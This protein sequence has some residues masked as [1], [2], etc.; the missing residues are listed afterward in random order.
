[1]PDAPSVLTSGSKS[2]ILVLHVL[3]P[4]VNQFL[5]MSLLAIAYTRAMT[6]SVTDSIV[7]WVHSIYCPVLRYIAYIPHW[8]LYS[9]STMNIV[10]SILSLM[11]WF[12]YF[13]VWKY[14]PNWYLAYAIN[15]L[16]P[17]MT[18]RGPMAGETPCAHG[19]ER[20]DSED[21]GVYKYDDHYLWNFLVWKG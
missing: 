17:F 3:L 8:L 15:G 5:I 13:C 12:V 21:Y 6:L 16:R 19:K 7:A 1:M 11:L 18:R 14:Y 2:W 9:I 20:I 10:F 4:K